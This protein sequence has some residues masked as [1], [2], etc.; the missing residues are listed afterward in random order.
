M[1]FNFMKMESGKPQGASHTLK[2]PRF[3]LVHRECMEPHFIGKSTELGK[4]TQV[5]T[6]LS[7]EVSKLEFE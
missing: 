2:I 5:Q 1:Y 7:P 6:T 4:P 3:A